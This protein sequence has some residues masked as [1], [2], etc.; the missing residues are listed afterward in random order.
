VGDDG[1]E[2]EAMNF[3]VIGSAV[4][5]VGILAGAVA[6]YITWRKGRR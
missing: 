2:P 3:V 6:R 5:L 4:L 1:A